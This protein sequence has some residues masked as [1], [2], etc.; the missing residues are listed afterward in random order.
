MEAPSDLDSSP[1]AS[2]LN[3]NYVA[4]ASEALD[5]QT[6]LNG[7]T[8][9]LEELSTRLQELNKQT[10]QI[11][12]E[13]T[14]LLLSISKHRALISL[15]RK[16][17]I[18]ILQEIF[19]ACLPTTHN[20][21]MSV[22]EPPIL[23][24]H[25]CSSWRNVAH[26][27][28]RLWQTIHIA[29][30]CN[31]PG[32]FAVEYSGFQSDMVEQ[33]AHRRAEAVLEWISRSAAC[34]LDISLSQCGKGVPDGF[35]DNIIEYLIRFS[36]RWREVSFSAPYLA[37]VPV[38][39]LPTSKVP[40]LESLNLNCRRLHFSPAI[41][42]HLDHQLAWISSGVMKAPK[43]RSVCLTQLN[44]D[45]T[46][47]PINW[48]QLTRLSLEGTSWGT[49]SSLT[50]PKAYEILSSCRNLISCRLEIAS[51]TEYSHDPGP[52]F[53]QFVIS[54]PFLTDF[55]V[56]E[57]ASLSTLFTFLHLPALK[58]LEFHTTIWPTQEST[59]SLLSLL[60]C[61]R[62]MIQQLTTDA[63]F[64]KR[65]DFIKCLRLCPLLK[66]LIIRTSHSMNFPQPPWLSM[67]LPACRVDDAFLKLFTSTSS[68]KDDDS[69]SDGDDTG[70]EDTGGY[71]CPNLECFECAS[72]TAFSE[73]TLLQ[74]IK[75]K[76][77]DDS[78]GEP[79]L[80]GLAKLKKLVVVFHWPLD[81]INLENELYK[82]A[83]L[84][85]TISY[86]PSPAAARFSPFHGLPNRNQ[87]WYF[88]YY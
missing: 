5:I 62:S 26:A 56:Y 75:M 30:P 50:V 4:T 86:P 29:V 78:S 48:G 9:R 66:S 59:T 22:R 33:I 43:L 70:L 77:G 37:L 54:L 76:N 36:D 25:V 57:G 51:I 31:T 18:D 46:R 74:F 45:A 12:A 17:P 49:I 35:Y 68:S 42:P 11:Q 85:A 27:T 79:S 64:F 60:I 21:V 28:P 47:L 87:P 41:P 65:Q 53:S 58:S 15:V 8:S 2:R 3:S 19:I 73:S 14:S 72:E 81:V 6:L 34:P 16:L 69:N 44:E 13:Q 55:S 88:N 61:S 10:S 80:P 52:L 7:P 40:L 38:A 63:Q 84:E 39:A 71:I 23:L 67:D 83:G 82:Q 1:F 20:A 32:I 24:T